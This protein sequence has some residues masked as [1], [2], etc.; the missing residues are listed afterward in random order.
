MRG[1]IPWLFDDWERA[2]QRSLTRRLTHRQWLALRYQWRIGQAA[3]MGVLFLLLLVGFSF[4]S[5]GSL[6][7]LR[8]LL[9][10]GVGEE[11]LLLAH[12]ALGLRYGVSYGWALHH[13]RPLLLSGLAANRDLKGKAFLAAL[14][15]FFILQSLLTLV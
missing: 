1:N 2:V 9:L 14:V 5:P 13:G 3:K 10:W 7:L 6:V 8:G 11:T 12:L 4:L 15:S